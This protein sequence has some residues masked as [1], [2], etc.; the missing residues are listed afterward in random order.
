MLMQTQNCTFS[1]PLTAMGSTPS[2][3]NQS[4]QFSKMLCNGTTTD[5]SATS[6]PISIP[7]HFQNA[8]TVSTSTDLAF[9]PYMTAGDVIVVGFL[10]LYT[11]IL[12]MYAIGKGLGQITR[13]KKYLQYG[14]GDVEIRNDL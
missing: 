5:N 9:L 6:S 12:S 10:I 2:A 11:S 3:P 7:Q 13:G 4:F 8:T 1:D 14:G